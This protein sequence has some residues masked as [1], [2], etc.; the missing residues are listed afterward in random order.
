M[1][2]DPFILYVENCGVWM[3]HG[4]HGEHG[5]GK[6]ICFSPCAPWFY[7]FVR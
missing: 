3:N 2:P 1:T 7:D 4:A 6:G 5:G